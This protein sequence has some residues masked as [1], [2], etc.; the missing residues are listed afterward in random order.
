MLRLDRDCAVLITLTAT[1]R[2][3][4]HG[5]FFVQR[6]PS[7][8]LAID[9]ARIVHVARRRLRAPAIGTGP[10]CLAFA[11]KIE[12]RFPLCE[13]VF[14]VGTV[15]RLL[16]D[17]TAVA[18]CARTA[19]TSRALFRP[20]IA[21]DKVAP[22]APS[23]E[24]ARFRAILGPPIVLVRLQAWASLRKART[25]S[26]VMLRGDLDAARARAAASGAACDAAGAPAAPDFHL[27]VNGAGPVITWQ[28]VICIA[29]ALLATVTLVLSIWARI[30]SMRARACTLALCARDAAAA[31]V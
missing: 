15:V 4:A 18:P 10:R 13:V 22:I 29:F 12:L 25:T 23:R 20:D 9:R 2:F 1:A 19:R 14:V 30:G 17:L 27:A 8:L 7:A 26:T 28:R 24:R 5:V 16:Q 3:G 21:V 11:I 6:N 31:P